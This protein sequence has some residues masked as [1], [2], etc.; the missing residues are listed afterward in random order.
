MNDGSPNGDPHALD[1]SAPSV[2]AEYV[3]YLD[4]DLLG[5]IIAKNL[6]L[7][8][9]GYSPSA[10]QIPLGKFGDAKAKYMPGAVTHDLGDGHIETEQGRLSFEVKCARINIAN[11]SLG[12][13]AENWAFQGLLTTPG[14]SNK[15]YDILIAIGIRQLGLEDHRYWGHLEHTLQYLQ[16]KGRPYKIDARP[17]EEVFLSLCSFFVLPLSHIKHNYFRINLN[18]IERSR[19]AAYQAWGY[20]EQRC[21]EVW[22]EALKVIRGD[23][24]TTSDAVM[25]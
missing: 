5:K 6:L 12:H 13:T 18:S 3:R 25:H 8:R 2:R 4:L 20:D 24:S 14:K 21:R 11:R 22:Q 23:S 17:H 16:L 7:N 9:L 15:K 10:V 1:P 19:Y